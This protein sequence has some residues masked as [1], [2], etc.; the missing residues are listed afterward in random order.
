MFMQPSQLD[1]A[2]SHGRFT[3]M[4][5]GL[6][7]VGMAAMAVIGPLAQR[8]LTDFAAHMTGHLLLGM[9]ASKFDYTSPNACPCF[10]G[11]FIYLRCP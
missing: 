10:F 2:S 8:A 5:A 7:G 11:G 1:V 4:Y 6:F 3:A 9:L